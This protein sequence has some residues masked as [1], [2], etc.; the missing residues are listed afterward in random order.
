VAGSVM[1]FESFPL[2]M[3]DNLILPLLSAMLLCVPI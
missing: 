3:S 1:I 2:L